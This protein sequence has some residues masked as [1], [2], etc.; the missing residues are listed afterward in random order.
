RTA[1]FLSSDMV[2]PSGL[3]KLD[4]KRHALTDAVPSALRRAARSTPPR[5]SVGSSSALRSRASSTCR[6]PKY[7]GDSI[8]IVSPGRETTFRAKTRASVQPHRGPRP[9]WLS[10]AAWRSSVSP[11]EWGRPSPHKSPT[12]VSPARPRDPRA[13]G[14]LEAQSTD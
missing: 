5:A 3:L 12:A 2:H 6:K 14:T 4:E 10:L 1:F 9:S 13:L 8:A 7:V 11:E